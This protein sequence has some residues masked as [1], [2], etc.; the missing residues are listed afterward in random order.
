MSYYTTSTTRAGA[1]SPLP[2]LA[3]TFVDEGYMHLEKLISSDGFIQIYD[4]YDSTT[5]TNYAVKCVRNDS[6]GSTRVADEFAIHKSVS[7]QRGVATLRS[8]F[9]DGNDGQHAF[10][11]LNPAAS[12]LWDSIVTRGLYTDQPAFIKESFLQLVDAL[13]ECHHA[14][15]YH[16]GLRPRNVWCDSEG[17]SLRL[18]NFG[19]ATRAMESDEFRCGSLAYMSPEC[20][21]LKHGSYSPRESDL[22]AL[23]VLLFNL[24]T[25]HR[26]WALADSSDVSYAAFRSDEENYFIETFHLTPAANDFL[27]RCFASQREHRPSL[28]EMSIAVLDIDQFTLAHTLTYHTRAATRAS[29]LRVF[30]NHS[31][32]EVRF[33]DRAKRSITTRARF[34]NAQRRTN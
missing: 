6:P 18:A 27:R 9:T 11:V 2:N 30:H 5:Q 23:G 19:V 26:P 33:I 7:H 34:A 10:M 21:D 14:G 13:A 12:N 3:G 15:V 31:A 1:P 17:G 25:G 24:I 22:W 32:P 4:G 20:A 29:L 8:M 28:E 16:R